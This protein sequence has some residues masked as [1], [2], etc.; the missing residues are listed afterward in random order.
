MYAHKGFPKVRPDQIE[1][2][3]VCKN[4]VSIHVT[5]LLE[6][7]YVLCVYGLRLRVLRLAIQSASPFMYVWYR[8]IG[9][10]LVLFL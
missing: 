7:V 3:V 10:S 4:N 5:I 6:C 8:E 9:I 2:I 1:Y